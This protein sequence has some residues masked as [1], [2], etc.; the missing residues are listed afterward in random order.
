MSIGLFIGSLV[1]LAI[2]LLIAAFGYYKGATSIEKYN[3]LNCGENIFSNYKSGGE[4]DNQNVRMGFAVGFITAAGIFIML[5]LT[6]SIIF[7][8]KLVLDRRKRRR[9]EIK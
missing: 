8:V 1:V 5:G 3:A 4:C 2:G 6:A 7:G 9:G